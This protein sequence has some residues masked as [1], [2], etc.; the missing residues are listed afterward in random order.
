MVPSRS[1]NALLFTSAGSMA[2]SGTVSANAWIAACISAAAVAQSLFQ[3]LWDSAASFSTK[4][5]SPGESR[6]ILGC[7][8]PNATAMSG[9]AKYGCCEVADCDEWQAEQ[10]SESTGPCTNV[11]KFATLALA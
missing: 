4:R 3:Q 8:A 11:A 6:S 2:V 5:E 9:S 1:V 7:A 10:Y